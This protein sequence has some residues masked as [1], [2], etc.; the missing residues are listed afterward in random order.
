MKEFLLELLRSILESF[1]INAEEM[2]INTEINL[3]DIDVDFAMPLG[4]IMNEWL[5]NVFKHA[6]YQVQDRHVNV[7]FINILQTVNEIQ[8]QIMALVYH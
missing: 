5:T 2:D 1:G 8:L 4:L 6:Y 7:L 3:E